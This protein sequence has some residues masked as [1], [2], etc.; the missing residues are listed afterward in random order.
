MFLFSSTPTDIHKEA[1]TVADGFITQVQDLDLR[2]IT[3]ITRS[4]NIEAKR[5]ANCTTIATIAAQ[6][7][8]AV[9]KY[10]EA[11]QKLPSP[12]TDIT[13]IIE[14]KTKHYYLQ[15]QISRLKNLFN[16]KSYY[17]ELT[18]YQLRMVK[19][20]VAINKHEEFLKNGLAIV[21]SCETH[22]RGSGGEIL[23]QDQMLVQFL[24]H[25]VPIAMKTHTTPTQKEQLQD[26]QES[27]AKWLP[28]VREVARPEDNLEEDFEE[29]SLVDLQSR[30]KFKVE[31]NYFGTWYPKIY[32]TA[33]EIEKVARNIQNRGVVCKPRAC[34]EFE[35]QLT[36]LQA[37]LFACDDVN[38]LQ[39][40]EGVQYA[41]ALKCYLGTL[42]A[43][44]VFFEGMQ[45]VLSFMRIS[46]S[47][48]KEKSLAF[49]DMKISLESLD[50]EQAPTRFF[51]TLISQ[52]EQPLQDMKVDPEIECNTLLNT[53][54]SKETLSEEIQAFIAVGAC[55]RLFCKKLP[56]DPVLELLFCLLTASEQGNKMLKKARE[57][58][59]F[60]RLCAT[61]LEQYPYVTTD[62]NLS[63]CGKI[64]QQLLLFS[65]TN[66][67][68]NS[69]LAAQCE[70]LIAR[71]EGSTPYQQKLIQ[72]V[73]Q[74]IG[75]TMLGYD[76]ALV[77]SEHKKLHDSLVLHLWSSRAQKY[78]PA[79]KE[80][81]CLPEYMKPLVMLAEVHQ[82]LK[83][84][85]VQGVVADAAFCRYVNDPK[86]TECFLTFHDRLSL[87]VA[88]YTYAQES[89]TVRVA[90]REARGLEGYAPWCS[91]MQILYKHK[92]IPSEHYPTLDE[93]LRKLQGSAHAAIVKEWLD[94]KV[95]DE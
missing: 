9:T 16:N 6:F 53:L 37:E 65:H 3:C 36:M 94:V 57:Q 45:K 1:L 15:K 19:C 14:I 78:E 7:E 59:L 66:A 61:F 43:S 84:T 87:E 93:I 71:C 44:T 77:D 85:I 56:R 5:V 23:I 24:H 27:I 79:N 25:L 49:F 91:L 58:P 50:L 74:C 64:L 80:F 86:I 38:H 13:R 82:V 33:M 88:L 31:E 34:L 48:L 75:Q 29:I 63:A 92:G 42:S 46:Q 47:N 60:E 40:M 70:N 21:Q 68:L 51:K 62:Q 72:I 83:G 52:Y 2:R 76:C 4:R 17:Q 89:R 73:K 11:L 32:K 67:A 18:Q 8:A 90:I 12:L 10:D 28:A 55:R 35:S 81:E 39:V 54:R 95:H 26:L 22:A 41:E 20:S 30:F 69:V